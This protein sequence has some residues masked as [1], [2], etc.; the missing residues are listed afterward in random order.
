MKQ[1]SLTAVGTGFLVAG[2]VTPETIASMRAADELFFLVS[3]PATR[4]WLENQFPSVQ[5]LHDVFWEGRPRQDAYDEIVER[6]LASVRRGRNVCAAFY[7]HPGVFVH[8]SHEAIRRARAEGFA[9]R[10]LPG[11]SAEDCLFADLEVDPAADGCQSFEATDF[12]IRGRV[13]DPHSAL[14]LWQM[15]ALGVT[16][17]HLHE[18]WNAAGLAILVAELCRVYP[19]DHPAV[20]YEAT[21]YPVCA[22]LIQRTTIAGIPGCQVNTHSTLWVPPIGRTPAARSPEPDSKRDRG[23]LTVVGTG[24]NVAGQV[25]PE[26][27]SCLK[28]AERLFYLMSDPATTSWLKGLNPTAESLHDCY[29]VGEPG[30]EACGRMVERILAAVREGSEVC[31]AFYGHP[32]IYIP[33]GLESL[34]RARQEGFPAR[35]L[36][37]IS[38]EDCLFADLGVDPGVHGRVLCEATSFLASPRGFD[39]TADLILIQ[40]GAIGLANFQTGDWPNREGLR[41]LAGALGERYPESHR[42]AL[43]RISQLPIFESSIDWVTVAELPDAPLSVFSTL[44]VP[45]LPR[46]PVDKEMLARLR[47]AVGSSR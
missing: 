33:P 34:R 14:V 30:I 35:M 38:F 13:F 19:P 10:M 20:I 26:T 44:Y 37:A 11:V 12:L 43:Y 22:P 7:G 6:L 47:E 21:H 32:A 23:R 28:G 2:Q 9:A 42:V 5:S 3:E 4:L 45:P 8:S 46:R 40:V 29:R 24:Y 18:L 31:A 36:P 15:G 25:T 17:Y 41:R 39:S 27:L 1:G 16:T